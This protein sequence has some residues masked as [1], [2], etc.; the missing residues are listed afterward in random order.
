MGVSIH[1]RGQLADIGKIKTICDELAVIADKMNWRYT[2]LDEDWSESADLRIEAT[3]HGSQ[4][5]GHLPLKGIVLT[6]NP[7]CEA[8]QFFFDSNGN[9]R[10]PISMVN[11]SEGTLK[12]QDAWVFVKTQ[13]AGP[14]T[15]IWIVGLLKYLKKHYLSD[16]EVHDEGA[17]WETGNFEMLKDKMD[18]VSEKIAAVSAELSRVTTGHI[19]SFSADELA[20][21][22]EALLLN[23]FD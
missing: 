22:I 10:D 3:E 12:P 1:Y 14:E 23:K 5:N 15:H 4:I 6:L 16:L 18:L 7:K 13:Y 8:L 21:V 17:Y 19:E 9:L 2:R 11:I 20:S